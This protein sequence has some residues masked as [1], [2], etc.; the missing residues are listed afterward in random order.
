MALVILIGVG[1]V[2]RDM[3]R[4][5][6]PLRPA[7]FLGMLGESV[8]LS[9]LFGLV[10]GTLTAQLLGTLRRSVH[11][12]RHPARRAL[13]RCAVAHEACYAFARRWPV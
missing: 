7:I 6:E 1:L 9:V 12:K 2:A 10:V 8:V 5:R 4:N 13:R 11:T 3:R